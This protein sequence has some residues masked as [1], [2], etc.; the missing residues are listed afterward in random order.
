MGRDWMD[1]VR[2]DPFRCYLHIQRTLAPTRRLKHGAQSL[3]PIQGREMHAG[4]KNDA[5]RHRLVVTLAVFFIGTPLWGCSRDVHPGL[6]TMQDQ[7]N[8]YVHSAESPHANQDSA[9]R[10]QG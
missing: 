4:K 8:R 6:V 9:A 5:M 3:Y 10:W 7:N 2:L 1:K